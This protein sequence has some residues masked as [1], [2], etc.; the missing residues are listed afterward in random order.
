MHICS[1]YTDIDTKSGTLLPNPYKKFSPGH[2][3][4]IDQIKISANQNHANQNRVDQNRLIQ[5]HPQGLC[6]GRRVPRRG[7]A[8]VF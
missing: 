8:A 2:M 4:P 1:I 7:R 6:N 5:N 3:S